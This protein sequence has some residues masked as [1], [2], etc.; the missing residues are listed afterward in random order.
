MMISKFPTINA[1]YFSKYVTSMHNESDVPFR[2][3]MG[4]LAFTFVHEEAVVL[5]SHFSVDSKQIGVSFKP[6]ANKIVCTIK[7]VP[8]VHKNPNRP[9]FMVFNKMTL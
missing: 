8:A 1:P 3:C 7:N 5:A 6:I 4:S 9:P 2:K